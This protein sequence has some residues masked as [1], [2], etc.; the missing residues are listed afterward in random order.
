MCMFWCRF[1]YLFFGYYS[2]F[3]SSLWSESIASTHDVYFFCCCWFV[4][5]S[6]LHE[7][8][9]NSIRYRLNVKKKTNE[10]VGD[11]CAHVFVREKSKRNVKP[12]MEKKINCIWDWI[13]MVS[14]KEDCI[15]ENG[16]LLKTNVHTKLKEL[17]RL[18]NQNQQ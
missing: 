11:T 5:A 13:Q 3:E 18:S 12:T 9:L 2:Y 17:N 15:I 14:N 4:L 10:R 1:L 8:A 16:F 7:I 6:F